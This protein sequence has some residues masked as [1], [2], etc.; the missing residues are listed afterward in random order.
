MRFQMEQAGDDISSLPNREV[1]YL[2]RGRKLK[3]NKIKVCLVHGSFFET[4]HGE[5]LIQKAF[6]QIIEEQKSEGDKQTYLEFAK[7]LKKLFMHQESFSKTRIVKNASVKIRFR[8]MTEVTPEGNILNSKTYPDIFDNTLN[9][10]LPLH[11]SEADEQIRSKLRSV[12]R[13]ELFTEFRIFT[14]KHPFNGF[15]LV[16]QITL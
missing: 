8:V 2:V 1:F 6:L 11:A 15:F 7:L 3:Q 5:E 10:I 12:V 16:I 4:I 13:E 14:I 9:F